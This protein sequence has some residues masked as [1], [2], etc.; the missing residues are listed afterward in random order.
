V[1]KAERLDKILANLGV[2]SRKDLKLRIKR[3]EVTVDGIVVRDAEQKFDPEAVAIT[4][5]GEPVRYKKYIYLMLNKPA[6]YLTATEDRN[7]P[8]VL[9]L[10][11]ESYRSF[12][13][14]PAG[15]LD[16]DSEGLLL[17]T[18]DGD[19]TH[20]ILSPKNHVDKLY[21]IRYDGVFAAGSEARFAEGLPID[22]GYVCM[23][24]KLELLPENSAY[25]TIREGKYHQVKRMAEACGAKVTYLR[26]MRM[27]SLCLDENLLSGQ[28]RE[29]S[30]EEELKLRNCFKTE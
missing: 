25:V 3:G 12:D 6:G 29:L 20:R 22:G 16:K 1:A 28:Y 9:D 15:R 5:A 4:V 17:L 19:L 11:D 24:A 18:N 13:L 30:D 21:F 27:G 2:G 10:L 8:T 26:R 23:P 14:F 7:A